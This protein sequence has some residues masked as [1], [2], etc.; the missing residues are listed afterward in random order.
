MQTW[1]SSS[2]A[3]DAARVV[4]EVYTGFSRAVTA[5]MEVVYIIICPMSAYCRSITA[6]CVIAVISA[7]NNE[8][9]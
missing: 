1:E 8:G 2:S 9:V 5:D 3:M 7:W 6:A 4:L